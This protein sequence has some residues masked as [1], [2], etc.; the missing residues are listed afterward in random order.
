[1]PAVLNEAFNSPFQNFKGL[2]PHGQQER[3]SEGSTTSIHNPMWQPLPQPPQYQP[4]PQPKP[5]VQFQQQRQQQFQQQRQQQFQQQPRQQQFQQLNEP[6]IIEQPQLNMKHDCDRLIALIMSCPHCRNKLRHIMSSDF[7]QSAGD[8]TPLNMNLNLPAVSTQTI[9]N[10]LFG[11]A[12]IF[13]VDRIIK[14]CSK[15]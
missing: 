8:P 10:F 1:M 2:N 7:N 11:I 5:I 4:E 13:L 3:E 14:L 12:V 15:S 6:L 9:S